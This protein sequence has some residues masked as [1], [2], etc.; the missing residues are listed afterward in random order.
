[1]RLVQYTPE[2]FGSLRQFVGRLGLELGMAHAPFVNYYY[3]TQKWCRLYLSI[4]PDGRILATYG[5]ET[6]P[7]EYNHCEVTIGFGSNHYS[8]QPGAGLFLLASTNDSC[9][10]RG[11]FGG[12]A[13]AHKLVRAL[14]WRY[15]EGIKVYV[16]NRPYEAYP[17]DGW[18]RAAAKSLADRFARVNLSRFA[19]GLPSGVAGH[20][21]VKEEQV[22][23]RDLLPD[24]SPFLFR[25]AP[26]SE[27]LNWRYNTAL[28]FVRYRIFRILNDRQT[29]GYVVINETPQKVMV[30]HCDGIDAQILAYGVLLSV[31]AVGREDRAPR[32]VVLA[33]CHP[34][35]QEVYRQFGFRPQP[36]ERP[37]G[38]GNL[39][40][41]AWPE[42]APDT[43]SW[44]VNFDWGDN[45][46]RPPFLDQHKRQETSP[47]W[48]R[49]IA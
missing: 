39:N 38:L 22:F 12:S 33:S 2:Q 25:F 35:M 11:I 6:M 34:T 24:E 47:E 42:F 8:L 49:S 48:E 14:K 13:D 32:S 1:M 16:L 40:G 27:Y 31:L 41:G 28:S 46:L 23:T 5:M 44:L 10:N 17:G 30:A 45:G 26:T 36:V 18:L 43:S 21:S 4:A 9:P 19:D 7:F 37:F 15:F 29:F 20:V 3:G